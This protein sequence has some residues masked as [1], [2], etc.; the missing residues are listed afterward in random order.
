MIVEQIRH[1]SSILVSVISDQW[2]AFFF[3][4][5]GLLITGYW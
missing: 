4:A 2:A 3:T 5:Y 1:E